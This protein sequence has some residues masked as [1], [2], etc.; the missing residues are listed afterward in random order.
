MDHFSPRM[1]ERPVMPGGCGIWS[2]CSIV[3]ATSAR[4]PSSP[5]LS[6]GPLRHDEVERH[7]IGGVR[8]QRLAGIVLDHLLGV[9]VVGGN[10]RRAALG[11]RRLDDAPDASVHRLDGLDRGL[12]HA[13]MADHIGVG[14]VHDDHI[15][16]AALDAPHRLVGQLDARSSPA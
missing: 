8:G 10:Q 2:N 12:E 11:H 14:V 6:V 16:D 3:G 15:I 5:Q 13:G 1:S 4:M 7:R 9:A